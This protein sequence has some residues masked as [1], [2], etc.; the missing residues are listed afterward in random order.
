MVANQ[1]KLAVLSGQLYGGGFVGFVL[2]INFPFAKDYFHIFIGEKILRLVVLSLK[3][4]L[5]VLSLKP[6]LYYRVTGNYSERYLNT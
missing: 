3:P 1:I 2:S 6:I 5:L 4:I